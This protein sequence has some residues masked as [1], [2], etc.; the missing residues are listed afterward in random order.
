MAAEK[1]KRYPA[2]LLRRQSDPEVFS[3]TEDRHLRKLR[4]ELGGGE[5]A[6][7]I[8]ST[9]QKLQIAYN[10]GF[11]LVHGRHSLYPGQQSYS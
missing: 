7:R 2:G 8:M 1:S 9:L 10:E 3:P 6:D 11:E 4:C 5:Q